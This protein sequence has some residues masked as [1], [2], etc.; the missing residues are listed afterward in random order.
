MKSVVLLLFATILTCQSLSSAFN[1]LTFVS[2]T[3]RVYVLIGVHAQQENWSKQAFFTAFTV[4]SSNSVFSEVVFI[5][6]CNNQHLDDNKL[7]THSQSHKK[8]KTFC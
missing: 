2:D 1:L 8:F 5:F 7:L 6:I 3:N 4:F